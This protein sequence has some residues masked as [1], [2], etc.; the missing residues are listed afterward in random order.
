MNDRYYQEDELTHYGVKGM[1]WGVRRA[2][3]RLSKATTKED[4]DK[5]VSS[6]QKHRA[7]S[8]KKVNDLKRDHTR[9]SNKRDAIIVEQ[10]PKAAEYRRKSADYRSK[11][12]GYEARSA[13]LRNKKNGWFTTEAQAQKYESKASKLDAKAKKWNTKSAKMSAKASSIDAKAAKYEAKIKANE[14]LMREFETGINDIDKAL[15][16]KGRRYING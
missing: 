16:A 3:K 2:S 15:T 13:K 6:L 4:Y 8:T 14:T 11:A 1:R 12:A 9:L 7:K 10:K 5:A